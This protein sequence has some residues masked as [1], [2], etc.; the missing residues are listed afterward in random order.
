MGFR[1]IL[2]LLL[3]AGCGDDNSNPSP[4]GGEPDARD[5]DSEL[6]SGPAT[7]SFDL[8]GSVSTQ[9][10]FFDF[11]FPSD[12]RL[13]E[14]GTPNLE[15]YP[16]P[17]AL[18]LVGDLIKV[19]A[20]RRGW[21]S[22][23]VAYFRFSAPVATLDE[24]AVIAPTND[25]PAML[26]DIDPDSNQRGTLIPLVGLDLK[27]DPY[28]RE[29]LLALAPRPGFILHPE[30]SYAFVVMRSLGDAAGEP[31]GV[32]EAL[33]QLVAGETPDGA[34]GADALALYAPLFETLTTAGIDTSEVAAATVFTTGDVVADLYDL[35]NRILAAED[36]TID[37]LTL[38][39]DG[40][41]ERYCELRGN[42]SMPHYQQGTPPFNTEGTF[43]IGP[44]GLPV[45]QF[46]EDSAVVIA[47][48][49]T[50]MPEDGF[51]LMVYFH[52]SGGI[53]AQ[54]ADRGVDPPRAP[55]TGPAHMIAARGF[56]SVGA[57]LPLSP[58][59][60]PGA[61]SIEYLN[62][63]NLAAF[64]FT[65]TQGV[66]EQ[67]LMIEALK[68]LT[69]DPATLGACTGGELP[70]GET[71]YRFDTDAFVAL[72]Q[73][74]GGMYTNMVGAVEPS[75]TALVPT[76]AGGFWGFFILETP[77]LEARGLL[78]VVLGTNG[79]DL[80]FMH[81][82]LS[83]LELGWEPA[84]PL[85]FTPR[86]SQRPLPDIPVRPIYEPV[87]L[88]DS[89]FPTVVFDA[90][91]LGYGHTQA[92]DVVWPEM[93]EALAL[94][95]LD[96]IAPYPVTNNLTNER[97]EMYTGAVVQSAGDG[98]SDPHV[99][100]VQVEDIRYQWTCFLRTAIDGQA[101]IGAPAAEASA[102]PVP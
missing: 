16:N 52:G 53:A 89:F 94:R 56:A 17:G 74:M 65:F 81:P 2:T 75:L 38:D 6:P 34:W 3:A 30:R 62:L 29:N 64:P 51:P 60:L 63:N 99:I 68:T 87:G 84:E 28:A 4:D 96:G 85:V 49:K 71:A 88:G 18:P 90:M 102:C 79:D 50:P 98:F 11:P 20:A 37:G 39:G 59:R 66:I 46:R 22:V 25:A 32:P 35:S 69:I 36:V 5:A 40:D 43:E 76:G 47:I 61:S 92:G 19:A 42:I 33:T 95:D 9:E 26:I 48:P 77:L 1:L 83:L 86:L 97:G 100:F 54:V 101:I 78:G 10:T 31:L 82:A 67:R 93:Q 27:N 70:V 55:G 91:A 24:S 58:D 73:S 15:G 44:D 7:A 14:S 8:G 57:A 12:L 23:P 13:T 80:S 72:G 45:E 21:A 41:H